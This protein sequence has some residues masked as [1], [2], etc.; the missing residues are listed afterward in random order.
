MHCGYASLTSIQIKRVEGEV[1]EERKNSAIFV[2]AFMATSSPLA[3]ALGVNAGD[4]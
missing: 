2:S 3:A 4:I 1:D